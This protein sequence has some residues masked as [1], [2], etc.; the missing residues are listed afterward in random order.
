[1]GRNPRR[2]LFN[3]KQKGMAWVSFIRRFILFK[4]LSRIK[5]IASIT[6]MLYLVRLPELTWR[7]RRGGDQMPQASALCSR[8]ELTAQVVLGVL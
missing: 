8:T 4:V 3:N 7:P 1:M 2:C 5:R 6:T